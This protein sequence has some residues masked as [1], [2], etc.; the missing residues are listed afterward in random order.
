MSERSL[1]LIRHGQASFGAADYDRLSPL[2]EEQSRRLGAWLAAS[3]SRPDL[4][5]IGPRERHRRTAEQCLEA[6]GVDL[7]LLVLDGLDEF[8]HH[9]LLARHRP[10]LDGP[11]ALRAELKQAADP[12]RAFQ[13]MFA[14]AVARWVDG[15][16]DAEYQL[17]WPRFRSKVLTAL[18]T[19]TE[20]PA[21]TIWAFTSGGPIAV[22]A[23]ALLEA[24]PAQTFK[25]SWSLVN[26]SLTRLRLGRHGATLVTYNAWPHLEQAH[27][28]H[29]VTLR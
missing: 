3:G 24:P 11:D 23:N 7:P 26:T 28:D 27:A 25:L 4:I 8:D 13:Q 29:L 15:A 5:A 17:T 9:E 12:H 14:D 1:L 22:V 18:Q 20:Q 10:D 21:R 6:A 16:H 19:L 2:G